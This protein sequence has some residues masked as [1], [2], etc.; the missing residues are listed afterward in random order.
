MQEDVECVFGVLQSWW[1]I[2]QHPPMT[3]ST[4]VM[5]EVIASCVIIH[6]MIVKDERDESI[7]DQGWEF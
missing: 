4:N 2:V 1:A 3:W 5:W 6:N 7:H